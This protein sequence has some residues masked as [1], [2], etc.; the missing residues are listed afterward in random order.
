LRWPLIGFA[1]GWLVKSDLPLVFHYNLWNTIKGGNQPGNSKMFSQ[2]VPF[3]SPTN[4]ACYVSRQNDCELLVWVISSKE[5]EVIIGFLVVPGRIYPSVNHGYFT[6]IELGV[7]CRDG[8]YSIS[9]VVS[10]LVMRIPSPI[11][12]VHITAPVNIPVSGIIEHIVIVYICI[13]MVME[14]YLSGRVGVVVIVAA[15]VTLSG[16]LVHPGCRTVEVPVIV[17]I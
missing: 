4:S 11:I 17:R 9:I 8:L 15:I 14:F 10:P 13:M 3:W 1:I 7:K 2:E 16:I 5:K 12:S 6:Q